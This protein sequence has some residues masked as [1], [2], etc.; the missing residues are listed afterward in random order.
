[1]IKRSASTLVGLVGLVVTLVGRAPAAGAAPP[2]APPAG[3]TTGLVLEFYSGDRPEDADQ[4][5]APALSALAARGFAAGPGQTAHIIESH[6]SR[7]GM[8][9]KVSAQT[10]RDS[11]QTGYHEFL[12]SNY[13]AAVDDLGGVLEVIHANPALVAIDQSLRPPTMRALVGL[14]LSLRRMGREDQA[15]ATMAELVRSFPSAEIST[16]E[17]GPEPAEFFR[18]TV[19]LLSQ[20]GNG[21]LEVE[22]NDPTAVIFVNESFRAVARASLSLTPG[23]YRVYVQRGKTV[24]RVYDVAIEP[25]RTHRLAVDLDLDESLHTG[26]RWSGLV[27][28]PGPDRTAQAIDDAARLGRAAGTDRVILLGIDDQGGRKQLVGTVV[29]MTGR[30]LRRQASLSLT[31]VPSIEARAALGRFLA[32]EDPTHEIDVSIEDGQPF[33]A[34]APERTGHST[35]WKWLAGGGAV[36]A[37]A[38]GV[39]LIGLDGGCRNQSRTP[40][41]PCPRLWNTAAAGWASVGVAAALGATAGYLFWRDAHQREASRIDVAVVPSGGGMAVWAGL[42]F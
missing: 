8:A 32:G 36:A 41:A 6:V 20:R 13:Q 26:T 9:S 17:Y 10:L 18:K 35:A 40:G 29:A 7:P 31:P 22:T 27:L 14:A 2:D 19:T 25:N 11:I 15:A 30:D 1:M 24:G 21:E 34:A 39:V 12:V 33:A 37:A 23:T 5:L 3:H 38:T 16:R 4:L 42:Q 28:P